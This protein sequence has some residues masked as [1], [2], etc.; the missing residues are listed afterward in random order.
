MLNEDEGTQREQNEHDVSKQE[1]AK[2]NAYRVED[3]DNLEEK[4]LKTHYL[5]GE[6]KMKSATDPGMEGQG[7]GG[8]KFGENSLTP[9]GNDKGNPPEN[10][11]TG[12]AYF[13]RAQPAEE[14][15]EDSNFEPKKQQH[16]P[17]I[18]APGE[19]PAQQKVGEDNDGKRPHEQ[20]PYREG[21]ADNDGY[22][23]E[24]DHVET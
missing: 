16:E 4:D 23:P 15:P 11:G 18:P 22:K 6:G 20:E 14:H 21:T 5:F 19:L 17:N 9:S 13:N 12:N 3:G 24:R 7:M 8:E 1:N 2:P 10:A